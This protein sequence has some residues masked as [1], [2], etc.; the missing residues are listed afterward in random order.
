MA[1]CELSVRERIENM[2]AK[3]RKYAARSLRSDDCL[4]AAMLVFGLSRDLGLPRC[5]MQA[6]TA[7]FP[8]FAEGVRVSD[9]TQTHFGYEW[10]LDKT[11]LSLVMKLYL[12]EMHCW[13]AYPSLGLIVD[14]S[15]GW[16]VAQATKN[17][18]DI[19]NPSLPKWIVAD[20]DEIE[21]MRMRYNADFMA[22]SL[23]DA[24]ACHL[25]GVADPLC[26]WIAT[27]SSMIGD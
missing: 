6:G 7:F 25:R 5:I 24:L 18:M 2:A 12:P 11:S 20:A 13:C 4:G 14:V 10:K 19:L 16:Q 1:S 22:C 15:V 9:E 26:S 17:G 21:R 23:A 27:A 8:R 3:A